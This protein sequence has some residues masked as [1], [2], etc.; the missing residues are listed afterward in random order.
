MTPADYMTVAQ[1]AEVLGLSKQRVWVLIKQGRLGDTWQ[2]GP[3]VV[4]LLRAKVAGFERRKRGRPKTPPKPT[5]G[6]L[7]LT[8]FITF[9]CITSPQRGIWADELFRAY[10][11]WSEGEGLEPA[12]F[13]MFGRAIA[14]IGIQ[15]SMKNYKPRRMKTWYQGIDLRRNV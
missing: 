11:A 6:Q 7:D 15:R 9:R 5:P 8:D 4:L 1:A 10:Q 2:P 14:R 12:T 3:N 13:H